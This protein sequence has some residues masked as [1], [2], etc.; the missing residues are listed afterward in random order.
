MHIIVTSSS[1]VHT[2]LVYIS[3]IY[4][5]YQC[6]LRCSSVKLETMGISIIKKF[7][8]VWMIQHVYV[9]DIFYLTCTLSSKFENNNNKSKP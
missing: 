5:T 6:G 9:F 7:L 8:Y 1:F 2:I 3:Y 4:Y